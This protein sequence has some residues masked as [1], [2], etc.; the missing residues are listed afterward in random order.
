MPNYRGVEQSDLVRSIND[1]LELLENHSTGP[2]C[3]K[4]VDKLRATDPKTGVSQL[5]A[6]MAAANDDELRIAVR[7]SSAAWLFICTDEVLQY[8]AVYNTDGKGRDVVERLHQWGA[9]DG[10]RVASYNPIDAE[11]DGWLAVN[12]ARR[13]EPSEEN[14]Q[15]IAGVASAL[16]QDAV[17][18]G[19]AF[20]AMTKMIE[21]HQKGASDDALRNI[22]LELD[23]HERYVTRGT[24]SAL[25]LDGAESDLEFES[26]TGRFGVV[27]DDL[28]T[29][30][31]KGREPEIDALR[32]KVEQALDPF[33]TT[34]E[35]NM[36]GIGL[37]TRAPFVKGE[38]PQGI[39][40]GCSRRAAQAVADAL[41][42]M[43][44][45]DEEGHRLAPNTLRP[46]PPK[47]G[48]TL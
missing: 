15:K 1:A 47:P 37:I 45:L 48:F 35:V 30:K 12:Y 31:L 38:S 19:N 43:K 33:Y 40:I 6:I 46:I 7:S 42:D 24:L 25:S 44:V 23:L 32:Q 39:V 13:V 16:T 17:A 3:Q 8:H 10:A 18:L 14:L 5:G 4:L 2:E 41:P 34:D 22:F 28:T 20:N 27:V 29:G 21:L 9:S 11:C 26:P 36:T